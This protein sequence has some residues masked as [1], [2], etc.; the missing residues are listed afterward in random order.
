MSRLLKEP[1]LHFVLLGA[2]LFALDASLRERTASA[3]AGEIVVSQGRIENLAGLF[4]KTWQRPPN[5]E[6][7]EKRKGEN[8]PL[9]DRTNDTDVQLRHAFTTI[10]VGTPEAIEAEMRR[11]DK[12]GK[13]LIHNGR[14]KTKL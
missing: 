10:W 11:L 12:T 14:V 13:W 5:A 2:L 8:N 7:T 6:Y 4:A 3:S 1:P 9:V